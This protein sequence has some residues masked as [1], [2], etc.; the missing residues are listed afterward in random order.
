MKNISTLLLIFM[1]SL[2]MKAEVSIS[3]KNALVNFYNATNGQ[4]WTSKWDLNTPVSS[5]YGVDVQDNKEVASQREAGI[6]PDNLL[7]DKLSETKDFIVPIDEGI[8]P[9]I[10]FFNKFNFFK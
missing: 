3:E 7:K 8:V 10:E 2:I 9:E 1:V 4:N 6:I 5:W